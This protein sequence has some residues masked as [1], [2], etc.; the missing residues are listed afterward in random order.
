MNYKKR[1]ALLQKKLRRKKVDALLVARPENRRYLTGYQGG[2]H[3]IAESSGVLLVEA[4]GGVHLLTDSRF[5]LQAERET[6]G[7]DIYVYRK[8]LLKYLSKMLPDLGVKK[9][10]FETD[11][12]LHSI[13]TKLQDNLKKLQIKAIPLQGM[14]E[15][16]RVI[17]DEDEIELLRQSTHLNEKVFQ[18]IFS[19]FTS[20]DTE[21]DVALAIETTMRKLGA[22]A[23][24]FE[25]I[26]AT[27]A[28]GALPHAV[29]GLSKIEPDKS[30]TI[31]MG[32]I[33]DGYCSDMTRNFVPA[34][35][36]KKYRKLHR[37]VRKAQLAGMAT[38]RAGVRGVEADKAARS[39]IENAG[40]GKYFGHSLGHGVGLAVH[41]EPRLSP[42]SRKKLKAGMIVT[43]EPGI[44][45]PGWGG[46]RL[47]NILVVRKDGSENLNR[48]TTWL[49][50]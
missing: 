29:P 20:Y 37:I 1:I 44:Y 10:A 2:D 32:L 17:K 40:Y 11:Y 3:G 50:I 25:T 36:S 18:K 35:P 42:L 31:D 47:E 22:E 12:T 15:G 21:L 24:S 16:L 13:A 8:G 34:K 39:V 6:N 43:V 46:I 38:I 49:D 4:R 30:M 26:V 33:L 41:E 19:S 27:G 28:N 23:P 7:I 45:I 14:V 48:D 5:E 9:V